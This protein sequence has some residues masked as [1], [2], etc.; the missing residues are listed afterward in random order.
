MVACLNRRTSG[1]DTAEVNH[2]ELVDAFLDWRETFFVAAKATYAS[3]IT[4]Q[5]NRDV[6]DFPAY[7]VRKFPNF[8]PL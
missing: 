3:G 4:V 2:E 8:Q 7:A 6:R 1:L 5:R